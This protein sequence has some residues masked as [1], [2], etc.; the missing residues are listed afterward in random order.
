MLLGSSSQFRMSH[1]WL[2]I[3]LIFETAASQSLWLETVLHFKLLCIY[4]QKWHKVCLIPSDDNLMAEPVTCN[5][6]H[7]RRPHRARWRTSCSLQGALSTSIYDKHDI[8]LQL[9]GKKV[10]TSIKHCLN[11]SSLYMKISKMQHLR[12]YVLLLYFHCTVFLRK[13]TQLEQNT[14]V[15]VAPL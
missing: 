3:L 9:Q 14:N 11:R 2:F 8:Q 5:K 15:T 10:Q 1:A 13:K 7:M 6:H 12:S 4:I